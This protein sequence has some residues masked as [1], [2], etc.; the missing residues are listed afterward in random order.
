MMFLWR[1]FLFPGLNSR[2]ETQKEEI[3]FFFFE[4]NSFSERHGCSDSPGLPLWRALSDTLPIT[5]NLLIRRVDV[6]PTCPKCADCH[7]NVFHALVLCTYSQLVWHELNLPTVP[8]GGGSFSVWLTFIFMN[9]SEGDIRLAVAALYYSWRARNSAVWDGFLP[10]PRRIKQSAKA[11]L[12]AWTAVHHT[13]AAVADHTGAQADSEQHQ[14]MSPKCYFDAGFMPNTLKSSFGAVLLS[15]DGAFMAACGGTLSDCF[16]PLMAEAEACRITLTW[17]RGK[18]LDSVALFS[19]CSQLCSYLSQECSIRSHAGFA[20]HAC[21]A[22]RATFHSCVVTFIPRS[23]NALAHTLAT[24]AFSQTSTVYSD[25][26]PPNSISA[27]L[28]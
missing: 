4:P 8:A 16:S 2:I 22:L 9:F 17:L 24:S 28:H 5:T 18:G 7:E 13:Q 27:L 23:D 12:Q 6:D 26:V 14:N 21:K 20:I 11:A 19:D 3:V 15:P 1:Y 10:L 25:S